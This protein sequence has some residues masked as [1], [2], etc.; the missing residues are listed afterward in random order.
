M[1]EWIGIREAE[2]VLGIIDRVENG[3]LELLS[4]ETLQL[5]TEKNPNPL[6]RRF[7]LEVL[8]LASREVE[9]TEQIATRAHTY[10][11]VGI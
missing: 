2:A 5:E 4:S 1:A 11:E 6:R 10:K 9:V 7:A 8:R 3:E